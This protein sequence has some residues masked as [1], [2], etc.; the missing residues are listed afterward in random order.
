MSNSLKIAYPV[1]LDIN[2]DVKNQL[3]LAAFP[4]LIIVN[5]AGKLV[6]VHEGYADGYNEE[7]TKAIEENLKEL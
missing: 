7:I 3:N 6:F 4:T 5:A 2:A 1:L